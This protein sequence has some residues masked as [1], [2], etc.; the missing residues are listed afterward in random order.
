M[1]N[2]RKTGCVTQNEVDSAGFGNGIIICVLSKCES[3][4]AARHVI[5]TMYGDVGFR[6]M[7]SGI[8]ELCALI[9]G[10]LNHNSRVCNDE[11]LLRALEY[12]MPALK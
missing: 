7:N 8:V 1:V 9:L 5:C 6:P 3:A 4:I 11:W 2:S 10:T 12:L